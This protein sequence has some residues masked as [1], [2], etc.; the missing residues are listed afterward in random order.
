M[1]H[2][3]N[4]TQG[5]QLAVSADVPKAFGLNMVLMGVGVGKGVGGTVGAGAGPGVVK[6]LG[7]GLGWWYVV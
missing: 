4:P 7:H 5:R 1:R 6:E 2:T 3:E